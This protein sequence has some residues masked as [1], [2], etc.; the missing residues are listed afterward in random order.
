MSES[1]AGR[2]SDESPARRRIKIGS[3]RD[4]QSPVSED[5]TD[6]AAANSNDNSESGVGAPPTDSA[7]ETASSAAKVAVASTDGSHAVNPPTNQTQAVHIDPETSDFD[8]F[9][10]IALP[11][12][13]EIVIP[14]R[15]DVDEDLESALGMPG[16]DME[17]MLLGTAGGAELEPETRVNATVVKVH[18]DLAFFALPGQ[19]EGVCSIRQFSEP[20]T[21]GSRMEVV[22]TGTSQEDG[23]YELAVPGAAVDVGDWSDLVEGVIVEA[24]ITAHNTGGLECEVNHIRGFIPAS[25][26]SLYRVEDF[27]DYVGQ[28][29]QCVV[30]EANKVR[31]NLVLSHRAVL[32]RE[33]AAQ[34]EALM[35]TL[36]EGDVREGTVTNLKNFGAFVDLGGVEG[37]IHISQLSWDRIRHPKEVVEQGQPVRVR[38]EKIDPQTGKISLSYR[39]LTEHPWQSAD[40]EFPVGAVVPRNR[41]ADYGVR[42]ICTPRAGY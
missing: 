26:V 5:A 2:P 31:R 22:V 35:Q 8:A 11:T 27:S 21:V 28:R 1:T 23:L 12:P 38:I 15:D 13:D 39:D 30:T 37:L 34:R 19:L 32:E 41:Y 10:D 18:R 4:P 20:P 40:A 25:Q 17:R 7:P 9:G 33:R 14:G 6:N 42:S 29:L 16:Q 24:K 36:H 3:Q